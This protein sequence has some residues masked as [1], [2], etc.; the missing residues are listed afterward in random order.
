MEDTS[1]PKKIALQMKHKIGMAL[2]IA[3]SYNNELN[4]YSTQYLM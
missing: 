1:V 4:S 2:F 3:V